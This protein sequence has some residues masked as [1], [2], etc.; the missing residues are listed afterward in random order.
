MSMI[1]VSAFSAGTWDAQLGEFVNGDHQRLQEALNEYDQGRYSLL[2]IPARD[3]VTQQDRRTPWAIK[4]RNSRSGEEYII[5]YMTEEDMR[6][7]AKI[8]AWVAA[9]DL[10]R[11]RP[12]DVL[13][14]IELE[15][16]AE[17][18]LK[19]LGDRD[20]EAMKLDMAAFLARGGREKKERVQLGRNHYFDRKSDGH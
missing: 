2:Y 10:L 4:E 16:A 5:R 6:Q 20:A 17:R 7:P 14:R 11:N 9:G 12:Q 1:D 15:E 3:R 8:L 18:E 13:A 19:R